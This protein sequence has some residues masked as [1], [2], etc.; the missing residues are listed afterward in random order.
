M[1]RLWTWLCRLFVQLW[2][3]MTGKICWS[4]KRFAIAATSSSV[5]RHPIQPK[6]KWVRI[7]IIRLKALLPQAGCRTIAHHFNRRW[8][9]TRQMTVSK[10]YVADTCRKHQ[11]QILHA[12]RKLK[13]RVPPPI[14]RNRV[15]GCDLLVKTDQRGQ[16]RLA[17]GA[18]RS[19]E[20]GLSALAAARRQILVDV[21]AGTGAGGE[22]VWPAAILTHGQ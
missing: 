7:E 14:P 21:T 19:W 1:R 22:A 5:R 16:P 12:R 13:H 3:R 17:L 11:Y 9:H 8:K 15:W 20:P 4:R 18:A 2:L 6:P 10:T